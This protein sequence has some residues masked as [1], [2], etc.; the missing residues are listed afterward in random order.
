MDNRL[1]YARNLSAIYKNQNY[2]FYSD[3]ELQIIMDIKK[4]P[5]AFLY[6]EVERF[7]NKNFINQ[8][9]KTLKDALKEQIDNAKNE[10]EIQKLENYSQKL[11][12][13]CSNHCK[14]CNNIIANYE[15]NIKIRA[16]SK[17][18]NF[19]FGD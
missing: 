9:I 13:D 17:I 6:I 1:K 12:Q 15:E 11:L 8:C 3:D 2:N 18:D 19:S 7:K 16:K 14:V 5:V 4:F 10:N